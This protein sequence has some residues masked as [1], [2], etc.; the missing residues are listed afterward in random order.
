MYKAVQIPA[1][2]IILDWEDAVLPDQKA[3]AR[4]QT[5]NFL[6]RR[7]TTPRVFVR[8]NPAG[9]PAFQED[10]EALGECV[11]DGVVLSKCGSA[12]EVQTLDDRLH[13]IDPGGQCCICPLVESPQ[14]LLQANAIAVISKR[15]G[16]VAFGAEDFSADMRIVRSADEIELL[17]ARSAVVTACRA[18]G[19]EPIDSPWL[20]FRDSE[21]LRTAAQRARSLGFSG[22]LAIHPDQVTIINEMFSPSESELREARR[23]VECMAAAPSGVTSVDGQMVDEAVV[24]RARSILE[25]AA[26]HTPGARK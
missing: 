23:I 15:V 25:L 19:R 4:S 21:R 6:K 10:C 24:R 3:S 12:E 18:V 20:D 26:G 9:S 22:K 13:R 16:M 8:V 1:D 17:Y 5:L 2:A 7:T 11:P 14:G